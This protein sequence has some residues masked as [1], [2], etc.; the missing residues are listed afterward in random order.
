MHPPA[1]V[2]RVAHIVDS[3]AEEASGP[4]Y[5]VPALCGGLHDI[6]WSVSLLTIGAPG[7]DGDRGF[8]HRRF[9]PNFADLP[10][11]RSMRHSRGLRRAIIA[12]AEAGAVLHAHGLWLMANVYPGWAARDLKTQLVMSPRGMLGEA[13]LD[14]SRHR[15]K[16]MWRLLQGAAARR[17]DLVHA[18]SDQEFDDVRRFGLTQPVAVIPNG[19]HVPDLPSSN[20]AARRTLLSLGRLHPKKGLDKLL[21]GWREVE[22][23]FPDW[24]LVIAGPSEVGYLDQL[25][26]MV[27]QWGLSRVSFPGPLYGE[28]KV[29]AY[30]SASLF[31]MTTLNENFGMTVAEALSLGVP[32]ICTMGA[33]WAGLD[34]QGCGWW[35]D[36]GPEDIAAALARGMA[37]APVDLREM[38]LRGRTWMQADF[39]WQAI[40]NEM[41]R[42]YDWLKGSGPLP[43]S[44]RR[45]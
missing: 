8:P 1:Q 22:N 42:V 16:A 28:Q 30:E 11:L 20:M 33:P 7:E 21:A 26:T 10:L 44:V 13:A 9:A 29:A 36:D 17:A 38:G 2:R 27:A 41:G 6:G 34:A 45:D 25:Q 31:I 15:K 18:T 19:I 3:V 39:S 24:D 32:V 35:I 37:M 43:S 23:A 5:S 4:S 12:E 14:F 40:A